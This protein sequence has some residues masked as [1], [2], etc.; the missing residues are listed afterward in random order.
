MCLTVLSRLIDQQPQL[1]RSKYGSNK[2][3][4]TP[5]VAPV[6]PDHPPTLPENN[7]RSNAIIPGARDDRKPIIP[8]ITKHQRKSSMQT[9]F[10][11]TYDNSIQETASGGMGSGR[12]NYLNQIGTVG[13]LQNSQ[14][15]FSYMNSGELQT[16]SMQT[17]GLVNREN[18]TFRGQLESLEQVL[19]DVVSEIKYHRRQ[20]EII[21]AEKD[22]TGAVL[23]MNIVKSKNTSLNEEYKLA[24]EIKR[25]SSNQNKVFSKFHDQL[26]VL[27]NDTYTANTRLLQIQ[28]RIQELEGSVG[29]PSQKF[30]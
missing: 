21:K 2:N 16:G 17:L 30:K 27:N 12:D 19:I 15:R 29:I 24:E 6:L 4:E 3:F 18:M 22:T 11:G 9:K 8:N 25:Q 5:T 1:Y 14:S 20:V 10:M 26:D 7:L 13:A 23:Q 28:R